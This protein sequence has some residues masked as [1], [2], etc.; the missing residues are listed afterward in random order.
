MSREKRIFLAA[1]RQND[2]KTVVCIG[3]L[4]KL[5]Q[6]TSNIGFIKPVGQ[7]YVEFDGVKVDEDAVLVS[8]IFKSDFRRLKEMSPVAIERGFTEKY[9]DK[10]GLDTLISNIKNSYEKCCE[11]N[12]LVVIEGTGHAGVGSTFDLNNATVARILNSKVVLVAI[13]GIGR[14]I[15]EIVLNQALFEKEGVEVVGVIVNKVLPEKIDKLKVYL[16]KGLKK[17]GIDLL[18]VIPYTK[19]LTTSTMSQIKTGLSLK[20]ISGEK[21]LY[22]RVDNIVVGAMFPHHALKYIHHSS[23]LVTPGDREDLILAAMGPTITKDKKQLR[24]SGLIL[25]GGIP[26]HTTIVDLIKKTDI[27]VLS[28]EQDTYT[29]ASKLHDFVVKIRDTDT[30]KINIAMELID[31]HVDVDRMWDKIS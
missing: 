23:L 27:P 30:E 9:L 12:D 18:G 11:G 24:I 26:T 4:M 31:K 7:R 28:A 25:T 2:G 14:P 1:T 19:A 10:G 21:F 29:V 6:I 22:K 16:E 8:K 20:L 13:G 15:D 5:R 17:K 3:L